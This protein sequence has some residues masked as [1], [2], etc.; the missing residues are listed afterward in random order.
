MAQIEPT[1]SGSRRCPNCERVASGHYCA[2]CGQ[3][4]GIAWTTHGLLAKTA[5]DFAQLDHAL[6]RTLWELLRRPAELVESVLRGKTKPYAKPFATLLFVATAYFVV[7]LMF[8]QLLAGAMRFH[9]TATGPEAV[10]V[11]ALVERV[12]EGTA[13]YG[14][15]VYFVA[16]PIAAAIARL[17]SRSPRRR[18]AE[19]I[20]YHGYVYAGMLLIELLYMLPFLV[21][22][23]L[24]ENGSRGG[25][26][27]MWIYSSWA[28]RGTFGY[29]WRRALLV[30]LAS[31]M[32][33]GTLLRAG[34]SGVV[35]LLVAAS[36]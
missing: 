6:A 35:Y 4:L 18:Y 24:Y 21:R 32:L 2:E 33:T 22:P 30:A 27:L 36:R 8:P 29:G 12:R 16:V 13:K 26:V 3:E 34:L 10:E 7:V 20:V 23:E 25:I 5:L 15:Y 28:L 17:C 1:R 14:Q 19:W 11:Q 9:V 31:S